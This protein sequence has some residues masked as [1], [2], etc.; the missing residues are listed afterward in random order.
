MASCVETPAA[1][2]PRSNRGEELHDSA[3]KADS[4]LTSEILVHAKKGNTSEVLRLL[5]EGGGST[6]AATAT[7]KV[8]IIVCF[9]G[10]YFNASHNRTGALFSMW[11]P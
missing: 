10:D 9:T 3:R 4:T 7:D 2:S 11:Q 5:K 6:T 8:I 1:D